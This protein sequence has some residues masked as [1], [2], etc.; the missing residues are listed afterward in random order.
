M[1]NIY[2]FTYRLNAILYYIN[3]KTKTFFGHPV[4]C[5]MDNEH[6]MADKKIKNTAYYIL[7]SKPILQLSVKAMIL[8]CGPHINQKF[9]LPWK[10]LSP[11]HYTIHIRPTSKYVYNVV[12]STYSSS[13][14]LVRLQSYCDII[15]TI[16]FLTWT[17]INRRV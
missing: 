4:L 1:K 8:Y 17:D 16:R 9:D 7:L 5:I 15:S 14:F 10:K 6:D 12:S 13:G 3:V 2:F 11:I